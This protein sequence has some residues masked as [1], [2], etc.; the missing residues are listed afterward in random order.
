MPVITHHPEIIHP[1]KYKAAGWLAVDEHL[2]VLLFKAVAFIHLN[3]SLV[4]DDIIRRQ[5][6]L[7]TF[8]GTVTGPKLSDDQLAD[9]CSM[10]TIG[11]PGRSQN[12]LTGNRRVI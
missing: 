9:Y 4:T 6:N 1:E 12:P 7:H 10:E 3:A 11:L 5:V 2:T 8:L